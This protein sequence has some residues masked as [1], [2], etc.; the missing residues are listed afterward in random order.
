[1]KL[2]EEYQDLLHKGTSEGRFK[3]ECVHYEAVL[4]AAEGNVLI[5]QNNETGEWL[6]AIVAW[7]EQTKALWSLSSSDWLWSFTRKD[8]AVA[9]ARRQGWNIVSIQSKSK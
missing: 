5:Y 8:H 6:W 9:F 1:M 4:A 7:N 3:E 2:T